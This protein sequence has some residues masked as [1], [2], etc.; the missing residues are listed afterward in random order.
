MSQVAFSSYYKGEDAKSK[1]EAGRTPD[2]P[3]KKYCWKMETVVRFMDGKCMLE[4]CIDRK[5]EGCLQVM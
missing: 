2:K 4:G 5:T 3:V 1:R